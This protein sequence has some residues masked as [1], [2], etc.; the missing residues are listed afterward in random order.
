MI[1]EDARIILQLI[2]EGYHS[3]GFD[4]RYVLVENPD[5]QPDNG[6]DPKLLFDTHRLWPQE[7]AL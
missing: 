2:A 7:D 5:F 4:D 6:Q 3:E 1:I